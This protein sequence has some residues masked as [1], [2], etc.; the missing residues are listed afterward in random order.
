MKS[1]GLAWTSTSPGAGSG[2]EKKDRIS[3]AILHKRRHDS[4]ALAESSV[5]RFSGFLQKTSGAPEG[6]ESGTPIALGK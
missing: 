2:I 5:P 3:F 1:Q 4:P 6:Y